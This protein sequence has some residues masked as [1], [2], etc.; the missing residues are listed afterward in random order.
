M[1]IVPY[2]KEINEYLKEDDVI[3]YSNEAI[4]Q[5]ADLH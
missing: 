2:A 4:A 1:N 5:L 3:D